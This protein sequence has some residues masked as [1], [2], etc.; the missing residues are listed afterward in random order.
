M[1]INHRS[2]WNR[3]QVEYEKVDN[4]VIISLIMTFTLLS[5][6]RDSNPR[7]FHYE[8]NALPTE[9]CRHTLYVPLF[10]IEQRYMKKFNATKKNAKN[11]KLSSKKYFSLF[12]RLDLYYLQICS[13]FAMSSNDS[14]QS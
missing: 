10:L 2:Q 7:P 13:I 6:Q 4:Y 11:I 9:P 12:K 8:W 1:C 5:R 14:L 3:Q